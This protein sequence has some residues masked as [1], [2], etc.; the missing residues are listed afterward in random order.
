L[1][2]GKII[3]TQKLNNNKP[4]D[5]FDAVYPLPPEITKGK[6]NVTVKFA[7]HPGNLAGGL[8]DL[9]VLRAK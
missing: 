2:D 9:R 4:G 1:V 8:F 6:Q 3:N 5:F 7:A